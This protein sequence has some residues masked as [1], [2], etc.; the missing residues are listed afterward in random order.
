[1]NMQN[2]T[3]ISDNSEGDHTSRRVMSI[4]FTKSTICVNSDVVPTKQSQFIYQF[5]LQ[6]LT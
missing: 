5:T 3:A 2:V 6:I 4:Y 1:M